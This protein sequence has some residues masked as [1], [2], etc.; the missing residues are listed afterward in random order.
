MLQILISILGIFLTIFF[1]IGTHEYAHF[2]T[3]RLLGVKIIRFSIGFGKTLLRWKDKKGTEYVFALLPLGGY[4][5]M[6]DEREGTV[7]KKDLPHTYQYPTFLQKISDCSCW[8]GNEYPVCIYPVLADLYHW[9][10]QHQAHNRFG[11]CSLDRCGGRTESKS[12]NYPYYNKTTSTW[13]SVMFRLLSHA[14]NQDHL[15]IQVENLLD[16]KVETHILIYLTGISVSSHRI[17]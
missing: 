10:Y 3:A 16:K 14:G 15:N 5:K 2:I 4:V 6:V 12:R 7:S 17:L 1:V 9:I 8:S 11:Y 13:T